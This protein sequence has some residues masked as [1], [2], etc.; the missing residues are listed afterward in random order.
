ML[1]VLIR[2][3]SRWGA[4]NEYPQYMF[5]LRNKKT[6]YLIHPPPPPPSTY[7]KF[8]YKLVYNMRHFREIGSA[9]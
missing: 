2:S 8:Y 4:S 5:S 9:D 1:W 6:V 7:E 3:A